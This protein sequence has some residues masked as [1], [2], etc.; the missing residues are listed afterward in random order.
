MTKR[1]QNSFRLRSLQIGSCYDVIDLKRRNSCQAQIE[2][3][4]TMLK[5]IDDTLKAHVKH[6]ESKVISKEEIKDLRGQISLLNSI[7]EELKHL[8]DPGSQGTLK[9][10]L[11]TIDDIQSNLEQITATISSTKSKVEDLQQDVISQSSD[12]LYCSI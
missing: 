9:E 5:K 3:S 8:P 11:K 12:V 10:H 7:Q 6:N 2:L 1:S 4:G